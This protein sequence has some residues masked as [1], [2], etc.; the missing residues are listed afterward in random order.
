MDRQKYAKFCYAKYPLHVF[1]PLDFDSRG[2]GWE[3]EAFCSHEGF[4][5]GRDA[6][7]ASCMT[8]KTTLWAKKGLFDPLLALRNKSN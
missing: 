5:R 2:A 1:A 7:L 3:K 6:M 8:Q 4:L